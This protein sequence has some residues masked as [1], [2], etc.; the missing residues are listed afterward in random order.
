MPLREWPAEAHA[1]HWARRRI[2]P[3]SIDAPA[4]EID[5]SARRARRRSLGQD[6]FL[7]KAMEVFCEKG[8]EGTSID[9]ITA[10]A[11]IAKRTIYARHGDKESLFKA[12]LERAIDDWNVPV[13]RLRAA[14]CD[15]LEQ[16]L[17]AIGRILID[18]ILTPAGMRLLKLT[19]SEASRMPALS[20]HN[21][22]YG[23]GPVL[24]YLADLFRRKLPARFDG[25]RDDE[26]TDAAEAF[27]HLVVG[28]PANNA[29]W[30]LIQD[31]ETIARRARLSVGIFVHGLI[32]VADGPAT[33]VAAADTE[34]IERMRTLLAQA[35]EQ[36]QRI[37]RR[38]RPHREEMERC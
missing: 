28:E 2:V 19:N 34:E 5:G 7:R 22:R 24:A 36:L 18:N 11:G 8:F 12:T 33:S 26:A 37:S 38:H 23:E 14:E 17:L 6:E 13:E 10:A 15:D 30:G 20:E 4:Q 25:T 9:A 16:S 29:A 31:M 35:T 27:L 32:P 3:V 21:V 1:S